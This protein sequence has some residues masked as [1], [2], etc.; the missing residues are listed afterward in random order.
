LYPEH[1]CSS[2]CRPL[3]VKSVLAGC[4][5][6]TWLLLVIYRGDIRQQ[7]TYLLWKTPP[8]PSTYSAT[9]SDGEFGCFSDQNSSSKPRTRR[10]LLMKLHLAK[11]DDTQ[12]TKVL[13]EN[14]EEGECPL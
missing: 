9:A 8:C 6:V 7:P 10:S 3:Q 1:A 4:V 5:L 14:S 13:S 11:S 12:R 2:S